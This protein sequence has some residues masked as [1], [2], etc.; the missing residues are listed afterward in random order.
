MHVILLNESKLHYF[1][2]MCLMMMFCFCVYD[3]VISV[4]PSVCGKAVLI[5]MCF[6]LGINIL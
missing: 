5:I 4:F 2:V 3:T 6:M 1:S